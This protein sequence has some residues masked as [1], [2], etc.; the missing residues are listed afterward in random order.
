QRDFYQGR[1]I[2]CDTL[3]PRFDEFAKLYGAQGFY[4]EEPGSVA[5]A[6]HEARKAACPVIIHIKVDP[7]AMVSFRRDAFT[8]RGQ[9]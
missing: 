3:N 7:E 5:D 6:M 9:H 2:G 4:C 1:Y 8:H